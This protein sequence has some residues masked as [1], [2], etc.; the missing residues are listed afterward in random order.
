MKILLI[1][2]FAGS[3]RMGMEYRPYQ[4]ARRWVRGGHQVVI[5][6]ADHSH[7]RLH[8]PHVEEDFAQR[9][10]GGVT[11]SFV[12]TPAYGPALAQRGKNAAVFVGKLWRAAPRLAEEWKPD[13]VIASSTYPFDAYPARRIA[14]LAGAGLVFEVHDL[15]PLTQTELY[16]Y[17]ENH[18]LVKVIRQGA[19]YAWRT[20]DRVVTVL[21]GAGEYFASLGL[22][23]G[24]AVWI[25]NGAEPFPPGGEPP[26]RQLAALEKLRRQEGFLLVYAGS[27]GRS[28][29]LLPLVQAAKL[30]EG[31]AG[32]AIVGNGPFKIR[33]KREAG[34]QPNLLFLDGV[35]RGQLAHLLRRADACYLG[36]KDSPLYRYGMG[37][38]KLYDYLQAGR[39]V[40]CG[41]D[42]SN[43]PVGE[44]GCGI[45]IPPEDPQAIARGVREL[46]ALSP[47]QREEMGKLG[48]DYLRAH[49]RYGLLAQRYLQVLEEAAAMGRARREAAR[50]EGHPTPGEEPV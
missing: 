26:V 17:G 41:V 49:H 5:L 33:L 18:P 20:A 44:A 1:D 35:D 8:N 4:M 14:R 9:Q 24:K 22:D 46:A 2:H 34:E 28:N 38:N 45:T 25:P 43:D 31:T 19:R 10:V 48:R 15:W 27:V 47:A 21:P 39:P 6:A 7:L 13:V 40:L 3:P 50:R 23:G 36:A 30:L 11:Y 42:A 32:I 12:R 16:G 29:A 37:M